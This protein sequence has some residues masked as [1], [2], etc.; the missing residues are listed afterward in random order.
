MRTLCQ[1]AV[2][3]LQIGRSRWIRRRR[4][5]RCLAFRPENRILIPG[6]LRVSRCQRIC[7]STSASNWGA[8]RDF[9]RRPPTDP[10]GG[11]RTRFAHF[12]D[13]TPARAIRSSSASSS[14]CAA[15]AWLK[16]CAASR[17]ASISIRHSSGRR[18]PA[19][20]GPLV[21]SGPR[22]TLSGAG[23]R[24]RPANRQCASLRPARSVIQ[25]TT[26][27]LIAEWLPLLFSGL[28]TL[29]LPEASLRQALILAPTLRTRLPA[30]PPSPGA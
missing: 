26:A 15:P 8:E 11:R 1:V 13:D 21:P 14:A 6:P 19:P 25:T 16:R 9:P 29:P 20:A 22:L 27:A 24:P 2:K 4:W 30:R 10:I 12:G 5:P 3:R 18:A 28:T 23:P 7:Q 17:N